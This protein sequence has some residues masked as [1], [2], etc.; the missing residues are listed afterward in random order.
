MQNKIQIFPF[1]SIHEAIKK[2]N[3]PLQWILVLTYFA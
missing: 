1:L 2:V 3:L